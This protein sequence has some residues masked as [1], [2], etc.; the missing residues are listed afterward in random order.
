M[1]AKLPEK[2]A[3]IS[4]LESEVNACKSRISELDARA[5]GVGQSAPPTQ[6]KKSVLELKDRCQEFETRLEQAREMNDKAFRHMRSGLQV[7]WN[8]FK[9]A[10]DRVYHRAY[11]GYYLK[12]I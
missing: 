10:I 3:F 8:E 7:S 2:E 4:V 5:Q 6:L 1:I 12:G 11:Q 9:N